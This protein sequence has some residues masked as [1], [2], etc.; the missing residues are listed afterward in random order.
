MTSAGSISFR[1]HF[2][3]N[4]RQ[5]ASG[6]ECCG[7]SGITLVQARDEIKFSEAL[8]TIPKERMKQRLLHWIFLSSLAIDIMMAP[9]TCA[10]SSD[11]TFPSPEI[12]MRQ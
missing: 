10:G 3:I 1:Y 2:S 7:V 9:K 4:R 5:E 6:F 8:W 12:L 11:Y